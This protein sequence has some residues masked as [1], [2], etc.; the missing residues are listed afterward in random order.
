M[1]DTAAAA[2]DAYWTEEARSAVRHG[3]VLVALLLGIDAL[4]DQLALWRALL[5]VA[6]GALLTLVLLP[7]R[8][9]AT[10]D[11]LTAR[12]LWR[13]HT[14]RTDLLVSVRCVDGVAHRLVL[15]DEPGGRV[16]IDPRVLVANPALWRLLDDAARVSAERGLLLCG[17]TALRRLARQV[18]AELART[19]FRV[20]GL[21]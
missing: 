3:L 12:C 8:I 19:V 5:W 6:L 2:E 11:R 21:R 4:S 7:A 17:G 16:E 15:R 9:S 18:D 13:E 20:S 10:P 14:V 1:A